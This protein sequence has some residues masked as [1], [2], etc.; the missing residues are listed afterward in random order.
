M[1]PFEKGGREN[2]SSRKVSLFSP[3]VAKLR[4]SPG[5]EVV[6]GSSS[7]PERTQNKISSKDA[8]SWSES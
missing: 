5:P 3:R 4:A 7:V 6:N 2:I 1:H 8:H